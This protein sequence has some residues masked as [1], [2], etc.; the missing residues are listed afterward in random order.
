MNYCEQHTS[1]QPKYLDELIIQTKD[2]S[3]SWNMLSGEYQG[4]LLSLLSHIKKPALVLEIGTY[5]G[6]SALCL[7]EG[8]APNGTLY[9]LDRDVRFTDLY[10][11]YFSNVPDGSS[12][13][14]V[15][16]VALDNMNDLP[17]GF[18]LIFIDA[19]KKEYVQYLKVAKPKLAPGALVI[20]DNVLWSGIV[21]DD[22]DDDR[23]EALQ[24]FNTTVQ[25]DPDFMNVLL[26][27][28]DGLMLAT[29]TPN[30]K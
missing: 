7:S 26:P 23:V 12:I 2:R 30:G 11:E 16:G 8:L 5:T 24:H 10:D 14:F 3:S 27:I 28:R 21:L 20:A 22:S 18:D 1:S 29:Y 19:A 25:E 4:R 17:N 9:T 6:F 15:P 13:K